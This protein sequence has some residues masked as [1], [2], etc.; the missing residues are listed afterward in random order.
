MSDFTFKSL[1]LHKLHAS[2]VN[3][4]IGSARILE[5]NGQELEGWLKDHYFIEDKLWINDINNRSKIA[6][7]RDEFAIF[8]DMQY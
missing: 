7:F 6:L 3:G 1:N 8:F 4:N 5:N 2:V